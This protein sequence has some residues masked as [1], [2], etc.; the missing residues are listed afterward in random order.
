MFFFKYRKVLYNN[1][2][3]KAN[4]KYLS[5]PFCLFKTKA[6]FSDES[7]LITPGN[8]ATVFTPILRVATNLSLTTL[9]LLWTIQPKKTFTGTASFFF[10]FFW[11]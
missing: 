7:Y 5:F 1:K 8:A 9:L 4:D 3:K 2:G 10:F 6:L 11:S